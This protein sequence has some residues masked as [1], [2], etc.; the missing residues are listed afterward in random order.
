MITNEFYVGYHSEAPPKLTR[1]LRPVLAVLVVGC[2]AL[3]GG[4]A[5][6]QN[7]FA[8]AAFEYGNERE[9][10]GVLAVQ[11]WPILFDSAGAH[12]LFGAGKHGFKH[13]LHEG[14]VIRLHGSA[15]VLG[16]SR[17]IQVTSAAMIDTAA[18]G[19]LPDQVP[20]GA[21]SVVGEIV[22]SKC[23]FG[24]MNPGRGK[25][26]RDC[27]VRCISG[28]IPPALLVRDAAGTTRTILL[29]GVITDL[30]LPHIAERVRVSGKLRRIG[31]LLIL[32]AD[33][34]GLQRE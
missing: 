18:P 6:R 7:A 1:F 12:V 30:L 25:V 13:S 34:S 3:A 10:T 2:C 8:P 24:V 19:H 33:T 17:G 29:S 14:A 21:V 9:F 28:G 31:S 16:D 26:H 32:E 22:D 20:L 15:V 11:P 27:A 4:L 23:Y 5:F